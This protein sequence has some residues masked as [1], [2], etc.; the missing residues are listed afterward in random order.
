M[1]LIICNNDKDNRLLI[2]NGIC[3]QSIKTINV[4]STSHKDFLRKNIKKNTVFFFGAMERPENYK[5]AIWFI[6]NVMKDLQDIDFLIIGG[7]P[8]DELKKYESEN[9]H[10]LGYVKDIREYFESSLC[11]VAPLV[12]GAGIKVKVLEA[13]SAGVP[14]LTNE[15]GIE[16][17]YARKNI[18]YIYCKN[19]NDYINSI[20]MLQQNEKA[21][22]DI[23][24]NCR[25]FYYNKYDNIKSAENFNKI[26][27]SI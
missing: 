9:V 14:V 15:I 24:I 8:V 10:I 6:N 3:N 27:N 7:N 13:M 19:P 17:I 26:L 21:L 23:S 16:G 2:D 22:R 18:E 5:S 4:F 12:A 1:D 20:H 11:M 25:K